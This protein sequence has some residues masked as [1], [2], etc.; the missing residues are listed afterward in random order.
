[1]KKALLSIAGYD[2]TSGAGVSLDIRVFDHF[3]FQGMGI[4]SA[5][6]LQNTEKVK[7]VK[8][9]PSDFLRKQYETLKQDVTFAGIKIGMIGCRENISPVSEVLSSNKEIPRVIDPVL[10]SSSGHWLIEKCAIQAYIES[11]EGKADL[12]TPN[13]EEASLI[14]DV[15]IENEK[16][17]EE[18]AKRIYSLCGIP[19]L[20][21]GSHL[22]S[23]SK[24]ILYDGKQ[25]SVFKWK[26]INKKVHGSGCFLSSCILGYLAR[27]KSLEKACQLSV[28]AASEAVKN[29]EKTGQGQDLI[30]FPL[31]FSLPPL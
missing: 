26:K 31:T 4:L 30:T 12:I 11:V 5:L 22:D 16:N 14:S 28:Q 13:A 10:R 3:G 9:L 19:C 8:C 21:K 20:L 29:A 15:K 6:T 18:A 17:M 1:M 2:P 7:E 24:D 23:V 25:F 27:G